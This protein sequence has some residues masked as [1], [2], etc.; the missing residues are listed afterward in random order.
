M[1]TV[2]DVPCF[3]ISYDKSLN[4]ILPEEQMDVL[5]RFWVYK[6]LLWFPVFMLTQC[7]NIIGTPWKFNTQT[8][9]ITP[10]T[11]VYGWTKCEF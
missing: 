9:K 5:V 10:F 8:S 11:V 2:K 1:K 7:K 4:N 6:W 3:V